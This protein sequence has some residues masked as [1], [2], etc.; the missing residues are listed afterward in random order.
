[1]PH[2]IGLKTVS[3]SVFN[4]K[5]AVEVIIGRKNR[6]PVCSAVPAGHL[7]QTPG[8]GSGFGD[9][10]RRGYDGSAVLQRCQHRGRDTGKRRGSEKHLILGALSIRQEP[11]GDFY[12]KVFIKSCTSLK[13]L[14]R[15]NPSATA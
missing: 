9:R 10:P 12:N 1:M 2:I 7:Q 14:D 6:G 15:W 8:E 4:T 5:F 3:F 13:N 11:Q